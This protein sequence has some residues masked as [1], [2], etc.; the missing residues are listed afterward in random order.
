MSVCDVVVV[1]VQSS[2]RC[3]VEMALL[4]AG[5]HGDYDIFITTD[6]LYQIQC[7]CS[8]GVIVVGVSH[9]RSH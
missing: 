7:K 3:T 4:M 6:G 1:A 5:L 8:H 9:T 2:S